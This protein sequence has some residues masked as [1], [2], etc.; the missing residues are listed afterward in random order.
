M[1]IHLSDLGVYYL[2]KPLTFFFLFFLSH[3]YSIDLLIQMT[4][5]HGFSHFVLIANNQSTILI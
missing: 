3:V 2:A 4:T 1:S 5:Y